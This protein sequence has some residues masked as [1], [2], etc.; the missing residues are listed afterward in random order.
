MNRGRA[1]TL[2]LGFLVSGLTGSN[3]LSSYSNW[4]ITHA[5]PDQRP[6][7]AGLFSTIAAVFSLM[8]P[9]IDGT[10]AQQIGYEALFVVALALV[11]GA[12]FVTLRYIHGPRTEAALK[13]ATAE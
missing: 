2:Y 4:V 10:I 1:V 3:L 5:T 6:I 12:L 13:I 7:Y 11:V 9:F 8:A